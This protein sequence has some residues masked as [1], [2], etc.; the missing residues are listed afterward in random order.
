MTFSVGTLARLI[1]ARVLLAALL[2]F[3]V[4]T[5]GRVLRRVQYGLARVVYR[6]MRPTLDPDEVREWRQQLA[7]LRAVSVRDRR[8]AGRGA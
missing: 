3:A 6:I 1:L 7:V 5:G 8:N 2:A 4:W